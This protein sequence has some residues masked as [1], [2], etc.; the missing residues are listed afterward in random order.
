M[1]GS[2]PAQNLE[3]ERDSDFTSSF[4]EHVHS[5]EQLA[6]GYS[7]YSTKID[8]VYFRLPALAKGTAVNT[9]QTQY[10]M[11]VQQAALMK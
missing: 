8:G 11:H 7:G 6:G 3:M 5:G 10:F 1:A 4:G 2:Y 9:L